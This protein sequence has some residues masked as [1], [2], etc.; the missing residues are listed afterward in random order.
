VFGALSAIGSI[1]SAVGAAL[2]LLF[3][4]FIYRAGETAQAQKDDA[5]ALTDDTQAQDIRDET[6]GMSDDELNALLRKPPRGVQ[7]PSPHK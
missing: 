4:F 3:S 6:A 7:Q 1:F 2:K 5:A